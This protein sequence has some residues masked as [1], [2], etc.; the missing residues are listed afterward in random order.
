M[1]HSRLVLAVVVL[2]ALESRAAADITHLKSPSTVTTERGSVL[3]LPP[4]YFLDEPTWGERDTRLKNAE[5]ERTRLK[6]ENESLRKSAAKQWFDW[7]VV[8]AAAVAGFATGAVVN[9]VK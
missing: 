6:A 4:G 8:V 9:L 5:D 7:K 1:R 3:T 2:G